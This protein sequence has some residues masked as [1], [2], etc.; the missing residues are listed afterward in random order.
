MHLI[1]GGSLILLMDFGLTLIDSKK[2]RTMHNIMPWFLKNRETL[3]MCV[4]SVTN[5]LPS[6]ISTYSGTTLLS[7]I[8]GNMKQ[9]V[10]WILGAWSMW[11]FRLSIN[12]IG[13]FGYIISINS[14]WNPNTTSISGNGVITSN[15]FYRDDILSSKKKKA[16]NEIYDSL[17]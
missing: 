5:I 14:T 2:Y 4:K 12:F 11:V 3:H 10:S 9:E 16:F 7:S 13:N 6:R 17:P 1:I 8:Y 15:R